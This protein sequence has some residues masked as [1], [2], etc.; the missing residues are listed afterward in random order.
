MS[1]ATEAAGRGVEARVS[2]AVGHRVR[3]EILAALNERT[4][5]TTELARIVRRPLSTVSHH[6]EELLRDGSIEV[7]RTEPVRS[8]MQNFYRAVRVAFYSD[9]EMATWEPERRQ[10]FY[11]VILQAA[12]AEALASL[13]AGKI[14][15]DPR[16][17]LAWRWFNVDQQGRDEIADEQAESWGRLQDIEARAAARRATSGEEAQSI[18]ATTFGYPRSRNS[19]HPPTTD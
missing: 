16:A 15:E 5:S 10:E 7:A 6:V 19:P 3:I 11:C 4:Y 2:Y 13:W 8:I 12:L 1:K 9:A 14:R 18:I 17:M